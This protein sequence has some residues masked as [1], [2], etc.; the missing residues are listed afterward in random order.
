MIAYGYNANL[1]KK[2][3]QVVIQLYRI[4]VYDHAQFLDLVAKALSLLLHICYL[5]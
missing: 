4:L 3:K 1:K 5:I 2:K